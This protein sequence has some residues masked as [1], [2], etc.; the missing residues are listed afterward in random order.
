M[1][2]CA[3]AAR[4]GCCTLPEPDIPEAD[5][6]EREYFA[7]DLGHAL[8][9]FVALLDRHFEHLGN[10]LAL[11]LNLQRFAVITLA[12][13]DIT[14]NVDVW[15]E[16]HLDL[17]QAV[18]LA[19]FAATALDVEREPPRGHNRARVRSAS[20]RTTSRIGVKRPV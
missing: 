20:R 6:G 4:Q 12:V 7:G 19:G 3:L 13:A 10:V 15:Q 2:R 14:R 17:D 18:A 8:K 11:V 5:F 9:E 16:M 1:T